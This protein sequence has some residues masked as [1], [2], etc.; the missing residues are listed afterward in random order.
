MKLT[1]ILSG[2]FMDSHI[3]SIV[4]KVLIDKSV[5]DESHTG[6]HC[7]SM[8]CSKLLCRSFRLQVACP[9]P[10]L[11]TFNILALGT[12]G[13]G[14]LYF[15]GTVNPGLT[16]KPFMLNFNFLLKHLGMSLACTLMLAM[17][18]ILTGCYSGGSRGRAAG[19]NL[20]VVSIRRVKSHDAFR[21]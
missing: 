6:C 19:S 18:Y 17:H 12:L 21:S 5:L 20:R 1:G 7:C 8:S 13:T 9:I 16:Q 11:S 15:T 10:K 2:E 3:P 14:F 4:S